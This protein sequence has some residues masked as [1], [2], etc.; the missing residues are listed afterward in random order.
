MPAFR[1]LTTQRFGRWTVLSRANDYLPGNPQWLC[2]C[3]CGQEKI[4]RGSILRAGKSKSCGCLNSELRRAQCIARNTSHGL[5]KSPT[6]DTWVNVLQRCENPKASAFHKYGAK[7]V[8][9]CER[10]HTF[11]NFLAD[12]G[13]RPGRLT[14]DR[15]DNTKGYEPGNCR[16]AT[17]K[18]Q[19]N[20]RSNSRH[21]LIP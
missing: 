12:M 11:E 15:I 9:V 21:R 5:S 4:V 13:E 8:T 16:W 3:E 10:W 6:Y 7:G 1:D 2:R 18:E 17:Q 19:Q 20:N 14:I